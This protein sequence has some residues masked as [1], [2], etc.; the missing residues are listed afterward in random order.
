MKNDLIHTLDT[1]KKHNFILVLFFTLFFLFTFKNYSQN[2]NKVL[3]D[4]YRSYF[5]AERETIYLHFN[6]HRFLLNESIWFKGYIYDKKGGIPFITSSNIYVSLYDKNGDLVK[7]N[8]YFAE[9]G[10]FSGHFKVTDNLGSGQYFFKAHTNWMKNFQ[11]DESFTSEPIEIINPNSEI[12]TTTQN[13]T[14]TFDL[15][16]LPE[17]GHCITDVTNSIGYKILNC[18]GEGLMIEGKI[19]N[20]K[21]D[22]IKTFKSN[23]FGHGKIDLLMTSGESYSAIYL[24]NGKEYETKLPP[25]NP[26]GFTISVNNYTIKDLTYISLKTNRSTLVSETGKTYHLVIHQNN[27][28]SII[29]LEIDK[30]DTNHV[31]PVDN[32]SLAFGVNT[33]TLFNDQLQPLLERLVFNQSNKDFI[34]SEITSKAIQNDSIPILI[35]L[36]DNSRIAYSSNISVSILPAQTEALSTNRNIISTTLIDPYIQGNLDHA[37]FYFRDVNRI[38]SYHL[39]LALLT[40]GWSK[41]KWNDIKNGEQNLLIPFDK[42]VTIEG[43]LNEPMDSNSS[44]EIQMFSMVN[45][46]NQT[47]PVGKDKTFSFENYFL[48]DSTK[49]HFNVLKDGE[50]ITQPK[51]Y[52]RLI[53]TDRTSLNQIFKLPNSCRIEQ[54]PINKMIKY[55]DIDF[56]G[57]VLDTVNLYS[58]KGI[59]QKKRENVLKYV[60]NAYS[61][62]IKVGP[63]QERQFPYIIDIINANGFNARNDVGRITIFNRQPVS[64]LGSNS[65][66]LIVD[67]VNFGRNYDILTSM[68]TNEIDEIYFNRSGLGYGSQGGAGVIRIYLKN[69]LGILSD[70]SLA[71][72]ANSLLVSGGFANQKEFYSP[73]FYSKSTSLFETYGAIDWQPELISDKNGNIQ[74]KI[75][76]TDV[77]TFLFIVEGFS[78]NGKLISEIK[79]LSLTNNN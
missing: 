50:K 79:E 35:N 27:K 51:L 30:L 10:T 2:N 25:S 38:K 16:F 56:D 54:E 76:S 45:K 32:K 34:K 17:G 52:A 46:I 21:K 19:V 44:Y 77:G 73:L 5:N 71:R 39:D 42:G 48:E 37:D 7:T 66:L 13:N 60:G 28:S 43:T 67:G 69:N 75:K 29:N 61:R 31:I 62:G 33:I 14:S 70:N 20:S 23:S 40:Q 6:K 65:P 58:K 64:L 24:I 63:D 26:K 9:N 3:E 53:N 36:K 41:Y 11:E 22:L 12:S 49:V 47:K 15:Q 8:L 1:L 4:S 57:E 68:R 55:A 18:E 59:K 72:Y 78:V 74:F